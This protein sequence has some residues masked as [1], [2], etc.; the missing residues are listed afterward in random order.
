MTD[1]GLVTVLERVMG[2]WGLILVITGLVFNTIVFL[3]C[4]KSKELRSSS[5][6]KLLAIAAINDGLSCFPWN[7]D[8]FTRLFFDYYAAE[9]TTFYCGLFTIFFIYTTCTYASWLLVTI[10][11]DRVLS[12][13][14][15]NWSTKYF[16]GRKPIYF[17]GIL[18]L[19]MIGT[20]VIGIFKTSHTYRNENG[21]VKTACFE[22]DFGNTLVY[23]KLSE[24][25]KTSSES[26]DII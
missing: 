23:D 13:N 1:P 17:A 26:A 7:F 6:F 19:V 2:I 25:R 21:T 9:S 4:V 5:T 15:Q 14:I 12:L 8:D 24:V 3:I 20:Y 16:N 10:S 18:L 11:L 22:E